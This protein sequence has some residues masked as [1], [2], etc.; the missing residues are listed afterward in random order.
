MAARAR[1]VDRLEP[2]VDGGLHPLNG[3]PRRVQLRGQRIA[4]VDG[5][6]QA[7]LGLTV[8][9]RRLRGASRFTRRSQLALRAGQRVGEMALRILLLC[10][11][12]LELGALRL[13]LEHG[14]LR[15]VDVSPQ[16]GRG[17]FRVFDA[18]AQRGGGLLLRN[19]VRACLLEIVAVAETGR[20]LRFER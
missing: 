20:A 3:L 4:L 7:R 16:R 6:L 19:E 12:G 1:R 5:L 8:R 17:V 14:L 18:P 9:T 15:L 11:L 2:R 10:Q 13:L